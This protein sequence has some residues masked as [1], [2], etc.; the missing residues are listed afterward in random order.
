MTDRTNGPTDPDTYTGTD[1]LSRRNC[2]LLAGASIVVIGG[3]GLVTD[4][5]ELETE[6]GPSPLSNWYLVFEDRFE[7]DTLDTSHWSVGWGWGQN[8][9]T[10]NTYIVSE[11]VVVTDG[12]LRLR[13]THDGTD[14]LS[15]AVNTKNKVTFGPGSYV[16]AKVKFAGRRGFNNAVWSKPNS[17]KWPPEIDVVELWDNGYGWADRHLSRHHLHYSTSM[18]PGDNSTERDISTAYAPGDDLTKNFHIYGVEWQTDHISYYVD[19]MNIGRFTNKTMLTAMRR[20]APFY[21]MA[22]LNINNIGTAEIDESWGEEMVL[23]WIRVWDY[24]P[25]N[26]D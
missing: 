26:G 19:G 7:G 10:S 22:S 5:D 4:S 23:D 1:R 12:T 25:T 20:G 17:E 8:T 2:L 11:N 15:G 13:G 21:L 3:L 9:T 18:I 6:G 14:V 16:E 24:T